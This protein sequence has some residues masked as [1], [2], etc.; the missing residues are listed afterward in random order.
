MVFIEVLTSE[1]VLR[2]VRGL[3]ILLSEGRESLVVGA[4]LPKGPKQESKLTHSKNS[5]RQI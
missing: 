3:T 2:E 4:A 1:Y 5:T